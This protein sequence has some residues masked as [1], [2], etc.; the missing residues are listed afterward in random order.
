M[1]DKKKLLENLQFTDDDEKIDLSRALDQALLAEK[2]NYPTY[3]DFLDMRK[4][5]MLI[6]VLE[7]E[8]VA[9]KMEG[10]YPDAER[11]LLCF[12]TGEFYYEDYPIV[13]LE[14]VPEINK[15]TKRM[16][17]HRDYLGSIL[18]LGLKRN[19]IGDILIYEDRAIIFAHEE[20]SEFLLIHLN[21]VGRTPVSIQKI[22]KEHLVIPEPKVKVINGTVSSMRLDAVLSKGFS[23]SRT[24][25]SQYVKNNKV[26]VNWT[27]VTNPSKQ[28][29]QGDRITLRGHGKI[30]LE[31]IGVTT[32]KDR[33]LITIHRYI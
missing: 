27:N 30:K 15:F 33:T 12:Y 10:G 8:S 7:R 31:K 20:I 32:K 24:L 23:M 5:S 13:A 16:L 29:Q 19:R 9:F 22:E 11:A 6:H 1:I 25:T 21:Q 18:G 4:I 14:I 17:S 3:T 28:I 2:R 26:F